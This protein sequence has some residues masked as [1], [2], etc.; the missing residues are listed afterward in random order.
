MVV[1]LAAFMM[2]GVQPGPKMI[3]ENTDICFL[4]LLAT[5]LS[6][7]LAALTC[8]FGSTILLKT[9]RLHPLYLYVVLIPLIC[10]SAFSAR[11]F[12]VD[13]LVLTLI[14]LLGLFLK[15]YKFSAPAL[16]L[17]FVLGKLFEYYLLLSLDIYGPLFMFASPTCWML[18]ALIFLSAFWDQIVGGCKYVFK[19]L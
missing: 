14:T 15:R 8:F 4:M 2:M 17:G 7:L 19:R 13:I 1:L 9:T 16:I 6:N 11:E 10:I 12:I 18:I 3:I 5:A